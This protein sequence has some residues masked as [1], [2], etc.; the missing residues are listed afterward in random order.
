VHILAL[1]LRSLAQ[2]RLSS[3]LAVAAV[4][5]GVALTGAVLLLEREAFGAFKRTALGVEVLVGGTKGGRVETLL[6][7]LY[8]VGRAPGRVSWAYYEKLKAD[9]RVAYAI[10]IAYGDGYRGAPIV[11]TTQEMFERFQPRPGQR[12]KLSGEPFV[13]APRRAIVGSEAAHRT[14][15]RIGDEFTPAHGGADGHPLH[16]GEIFTVSALAAPTGT[17]HDKVIWVRIEDFLAL[18]GHSGMHRGG[19]GARAEE[20][21]VSAI[22]LKTASG[23]PVPNERLVQ[24]IND[25]LEAQAIRPMFVVTELFDLLGDVR[26]VLAWIGYLVITVAALSVTVSLFAAM[27][28]RRRE[29]GILRAIGATR[30]TL[31]G[32]VLLESVMVCVAGALLGMA[33]AHGGAG[34]FAPVLEA[35]GGI[36]VESFGLSATEAWVVPVLVLVGCAAGLLPAL[37]A[38]R[39]DVAAALDP[40][41]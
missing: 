37:R 12:F 22:L 38:Y 36:R 8:H 35:R 16:K 28:E 31:L 17:A 21:A 23:S 26:R 30:A 5:L 10:P 32:S 25:S 27:S 15:L 11:G 2:R 41:S 34:L 39:I 14:G 18:R 4:A 20:R 19:P 24:D 29:F 33:L 1:A 40:R 3:S 13:G 7:A 6:S 9:R